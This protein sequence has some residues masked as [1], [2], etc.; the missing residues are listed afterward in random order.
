[1]TLVIRGQWRRCLAF[2]RAVG[3]GSRVQV[4]LYYPD[5]TLRPVYMG[6]GF[7]ESVHGR[8]NAVP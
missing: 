6:L 3:M 2:T 5:G 4:V 8:K 1:M 7:K